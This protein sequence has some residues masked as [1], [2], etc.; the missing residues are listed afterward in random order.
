[1]EFPIRIQPAFR[2]L[3]VIRMRRWMKPSDPSWSAFAGNCTRPLSRLSAEHRRVIVE[4]Y[5]RGRTVAETAELLDVSAGMVKSRTFHAMRALR[6]AIDD[7][8]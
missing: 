8:R 3:C 5:L 6:T 2:R 1:V 7:G 4:L